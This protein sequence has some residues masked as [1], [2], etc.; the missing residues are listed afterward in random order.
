MNI[1]NLVYK[2]IGQMSGGER[3]RIFIA[4]ALAQNPEVL[5]LDE[6]TSALDIKNQ[7]ETMK[8]IVSLAHTRNKR[9]YDG[10]RYKYCGRVC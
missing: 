6:P 5:I 7:F 9:C 2:K 3:Q 8:L 4:R 1:E 10:T